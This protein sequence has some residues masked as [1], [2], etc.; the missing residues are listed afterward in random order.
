MAKS[1][2]SFV[3]HLHA[4]IFLGENAACDKVEFFTPSPDRRALH[5]VLRSGKPTPAFV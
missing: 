3:G 5:A 4:H 2:Q 1:H